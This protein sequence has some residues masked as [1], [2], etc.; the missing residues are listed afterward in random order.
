MG[1]ILHALV[2]E[3]IDTVCEAEGSTGKCCKK[4]DQHS[5]H[6]NNNDDE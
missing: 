2:S 4:D 3:D 1:I 5:K 6:P